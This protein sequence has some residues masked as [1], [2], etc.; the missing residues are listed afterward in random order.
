[1]KNPLSLAQESL[2]TIR[3]SEMEIQTLAFSS[4]MPFLTIFSKAKPSG[5][6]DGAHDRL[7]DSEAGGREALAQVSRIWF[8]ASRT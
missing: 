6:F 8:A 7:P 4:T 3:L 1:M 5:T 2:S